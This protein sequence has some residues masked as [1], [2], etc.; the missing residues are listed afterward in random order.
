LNKGIESRRFEVQGRNDKENNMLRQSSLACGRSWFALIVASALAQL[1]S[2]NLP[3]QTKT[4]D[5]LRVPAVDRKFSW[6]QTDTSIA[7]FN[8]GRLVWEHVH[9]RKMGK[10]YMRIGSLDGTELTRPCPFPKG[11]P[12]SDH[13]WH[14][15]LWWSWKAINGVNYWEKNQQG[16]DPVDVEIT[17]RD[18]GS[19]QLQMTIAYHLPD[20]PPMAMENRLIT[21]SAPDAV[22]TYSIAWQ[23]T[24]TPPGA[25]DVVFNKNSY[26]GMAIRMAAE[27]CGDAAAERPPW[28]FLDSEG[29]ANCNNQKAR[30]VAYSGTT[31]S[32]QSAAVAMFDH[33]DNPRHPSWWQSRSHYPYLNPSFTCKEDFRLRAGE[34]L[35]LKYCILVHHGSADRERLEQEWKVF[36]TTPMH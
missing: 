32:G 35:T 19:A 25:D 27:C 8:H 21:V 6:R 22:G 36:A 15:A 12:K 3:G 9:D 24:F 13:T 16:T 10:P 23:A 7:L 33:P 4:A 34:S 2:G 17:H 28:T 30:W 1:P 26:G 20:Q 14:R 29:R 18:D 11:Y 31:P 5:D